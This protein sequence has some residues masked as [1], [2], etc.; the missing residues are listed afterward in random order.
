MSRKLIHFP[1]T[2]S[3]KW[4]LSH[5]LSR[6]VGRLSLKRKD[7]HYR[8]H[9]DAVMR[10]SPTSLQLRLRGDTQRGIHFCCGH[11]PKQRIEKKGRTLRATTG[12]KTRFY[13]AMWYLFLINLI[14]ESAD[15]FCIEVMFVTLLSVV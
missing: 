4:M 10:V 14:R 9:V 3:S 8:Q 15:D 5:N 11:E 6:L 1:V 7:E 13:S 12:R 2:V